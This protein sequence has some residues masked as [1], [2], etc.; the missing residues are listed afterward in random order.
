[1]GSNTLGPLP[2]EENLDPSQRVLSL[3]VEIGSLV[4]IVDYTRFYGIITNAIHCLADV[5]TNG[6][7]VMIIPCGDFSRERLWR[8][9]YCTVGELKLVH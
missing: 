4:E 5:L 7:V 9:G 3:C 6:S 2:C 8:V 1:M